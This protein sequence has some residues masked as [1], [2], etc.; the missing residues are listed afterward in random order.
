MTGNRAAA[1]SL[2]AKMSEAWIHFAT[3]GDPNHS[4]IPQWRPFDPATNG[5]L[6][7]DDV[8]TFHEHLDDECQKI[9]NEA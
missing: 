6:V 7:F 9:I 5:T 2:A 1:R 8:C 3:N 4:G